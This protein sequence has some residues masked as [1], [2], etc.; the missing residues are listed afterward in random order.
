IGLSIRG[1]AGD[2]PPNKSR[3]QVRTEAGPA[4]GRLLSLPSS[5]E[6]D[7]SALIAYLL[8][9]Y[10]RLGPGAGP[11]APRCRARRGPW[12]RTAGRTRLGRASVRREP[13][14]SR[15]PPLRGPAPVLYRPS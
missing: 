5:S 1:G 2:R 4:V 11:P 8:G 13:G 12:P 3:N 7:V 9:S 15:G 6:T 10:K 14:R